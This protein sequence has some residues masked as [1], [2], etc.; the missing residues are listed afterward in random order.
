MFSNV[1]TMRPYS[2]LNSAEFSTHPVPCAAKLVAG[3]ITVMARPRIAGR[4]GGRNP[5]GARWAEVRAAS[6]PSGPR[7][8]LLRTPAGTTY[9]TASCD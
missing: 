2:L 3:L 5:L 1:E 8:V 7:E 9:L 6:T 4:G